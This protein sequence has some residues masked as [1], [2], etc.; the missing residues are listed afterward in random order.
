[1]EIYRVRGGHEEVIATL[2][3][4]EVI[5]EMSLI[6]DH[7]RA[8]SART[9]P[10]TSLVVISQDDLQKH[11]AALESSDRQFKLLI[12]AL[13]RRLRGQAKAPV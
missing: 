7:P 2:G 11:M 9:R 10:G 5:G 1:V 12:D 8:A 6:D 3:R 13:V 4:G